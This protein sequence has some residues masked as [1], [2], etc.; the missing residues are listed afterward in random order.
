MDTPKEFQCSVRIS[1][2]IF[3]GFLMKFPQEFLINLLE[4]F[5]MR[6][7]GEFLKE[8]SEESPDNTN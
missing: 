5:L 1:T 2:D 6:L 3:G 4:E 7:L 8:F